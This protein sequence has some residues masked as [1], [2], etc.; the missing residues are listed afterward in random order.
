MTTGRNTNSSSLMTNCLSSL[1]SLCHR[2]IM[3]RRMACPQFQLLRYHLRWL[4]AGFKTASSEL[5]SIR[6][7]LC[8]VTL[9]GLRSTDSQLP[10]DFLTCSEVFLTFSLKHLTKSQTRSKFPSM[11]MASKTTRSLGIH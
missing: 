7:F 2:A 11:I 10:F 8:L 4:S 1:I 9:I 3:H 6:W 5:S